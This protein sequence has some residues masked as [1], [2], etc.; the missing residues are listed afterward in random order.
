ML[1]RQLYSSGYGFISNIM[2]IFASFL[3]SVVSLNNIFLIVILLGL[4]GFAL[5]LG[6][7]CRK[8][9]AIRK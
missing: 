1:D 3:Y 4:L 7:L 8:F 6:W 2:N 5:W 9:M